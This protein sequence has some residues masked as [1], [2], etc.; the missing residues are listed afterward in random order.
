RWTEWMTKISQNDEPVPGL[1]LHNEGKVVA[2]GGEIITDGPFTEGK[3]IVGGYV[4]VEAGDMD[5]A[6][7]ISKGC[8]I[9]EFGGTVEVREAV[10]MVHNP[11]H[12]R[13]TQL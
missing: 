2:K 13:V 8:P 1:P 7:E 5:Q 9:F 11:G 10:P 4:L 6:V 3:E 12:H